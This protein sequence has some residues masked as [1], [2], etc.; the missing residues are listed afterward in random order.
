[1]N[2]AY[3]DTLITHKNSKSYEIPEYPLDSIK[4]AKEEIASLTTQIK[5]DKKTMNEDVEDS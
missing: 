2:A 3:S 4:K 5:K 1:M